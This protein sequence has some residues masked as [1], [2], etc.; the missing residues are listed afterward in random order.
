MSQSLAPAPRAWRSR[1]IFTHEFIYG[2]C[3]FSPYLFS[4]K[5]HAGPVV[6]VAHRVVAGCSTA[7]S[8][9]WVFRRTCSVPVLKAPPPP[10]HSDL[11]S[12]LLRAS[13]CFPALL[14]APCHNNNFC[15][16]IPPHP[17]PFHPVPRHAMPCHVQTPY[18]AMPSPGD[19]R[20]RAHAVRS[21]P[22][23]DGVADEG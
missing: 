19:W 10:S 6:V 23:A 7:V 9:S 22:G 1:Q 14:V 17:I 18:H 15:L 5:H 8:L 11:A 21:E 13:F 3:C 20:R 16:R 12:P 2:S 4:P